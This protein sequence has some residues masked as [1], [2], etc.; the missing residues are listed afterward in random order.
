LSSIH[1]LQQTV[2]V[3]L[4]CCYWLCS[5]LF[6]DAVCAYRDGKAAMVFR[7]IETIVMF[8]IEVLNV[9]FVD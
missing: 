8:S 7:L 4:C 9:G 5:W 1:K 6:T 3:A 2:Q